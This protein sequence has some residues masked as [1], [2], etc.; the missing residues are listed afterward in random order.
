[1]EVGQNAKMFAAKILQPLSVGN[2]MDG[3]PVTFLS[4]DR[5]G[6]LVVLAVYNVIADISS[7]FKDQILSVFDP[8]V[9]SFKNLDS[10]SQVHTD[11]DVK[12]V[13]I[14]SISKFKISGKLGEEV[15][16]SFA[17]PKIV[18]ENR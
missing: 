16:K 5:F 9:R 15:H 7:A 10:Q 11:C 2:G 3:T 18:S 12:I 4:C 1:L 6:K 17:P 13:M 8:F 14:L